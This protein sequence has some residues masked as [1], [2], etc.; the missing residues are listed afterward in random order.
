L[1]HVVGDRVLDVGCGPG[2]LLR[3]LLETGHRAYG[4]DLS[5][6]MFIRAH[7]ELARAGCL[8]AVLAADARALPFIDCSFDPIG[9]TCPTP[10]VRD[11]QLWAEAARL[12]RAGGRCIV[13]LGA[14]R[15]SDSADAAEVEVDLPIPQGLFR[16][17]S[18]LQRGRS[19]AVVMVV[20]ERITER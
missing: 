10:V 1:D 17:R 2:H 20:A 11:P 12:L 7:R 18:F 6:P 16:Y 9:P 15:R 5:S 4:V 13:V 3:E 19:G 14:R 8:D